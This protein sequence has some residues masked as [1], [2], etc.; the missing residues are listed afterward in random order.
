MS[1]NDDIDARVR[2]RIKEILPQLP[3]SVFE[4]TKLL[5]TD[6]LRFQCYPGIG[7]F[8]KC[9][10]NI[11]INLTPYD[12]FR[13]K[14]RLNLTYEHFLH[15]YTTTQ[16]IDG[17]PLPITVL[18]LKETPQ[19]ECPF[20]TPD[21]CVIYEDRPVTC[22][23]YPIGMAIMKQ[24]QNKTGEEFFVKIKEDHCLG[25]LEPKKWTIEEWRQDQKADLYDGMNTDWL[26]V[27]LKA[28]TLGMVEFNKKS[29][30]LFNMVSTD[31]DLFRNFVFESD[32]LRMFKLDLET[33][34]RVKS[35]EL[36]LLLFAQKWLRFTLFGEGDFKFN[37]K[38]R[39]RRLKSV[40]KKRTEI[41]NAPHQ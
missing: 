30:H 33:V 14:K 15:T 24:D 36:E 19:R 17:T 6:Q 9:C 28:K 37:E 26:S 11:R 13:L 10:S 21:G 34:E 12:I 29:L 18:K 2:E 38:F 31:M 20:V 32:F 22:R 41:K 7:C 4:P 39:Q 3:K 23:Y 40:E 35:D 27:V 8:T 5:K 25:H 16:P 1:Y